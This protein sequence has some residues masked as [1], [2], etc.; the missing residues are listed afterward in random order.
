MKAFVVNV[1]IF[2]FKYMWLNIFAL[3]KWPQLR[4]LH[5]KPKG[6]LGLHVFYNYIQLL[7]HCVIIKEDC[8]YYHKHETVSVKGCVWHSMYMYKYEV[9][10]CENLF[11]QHANIVLVTSRKLIRLL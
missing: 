9:H 8:M 10:F 7:L 4:Q 3:S 5:T 2:C 6:K 11:P 1:Q